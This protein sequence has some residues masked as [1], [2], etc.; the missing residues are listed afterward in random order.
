[1][2][3]S[4]QTISKSVFKARALELCRQV[5]A[6]GRPLLITDHGRPVLRLVP[7]EESTQATLARLRGTL[8]RYDNPTAPV[9]AEWEAGA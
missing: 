1:M 9:G 8:V 6:T 2:A 3:R 7:Y 4:D 5:E